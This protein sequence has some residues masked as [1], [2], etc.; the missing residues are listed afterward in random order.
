[1]VVAIRPSPSAV[2]LTKDSVKAYCRVHDLGGIKAESN[3]RVAPEQGF[4]LCCGKPLQQAPGK[5]KIK[6]C[7]AECRQRWWNAHPEAVQTESCLYFHLRP[8]RTLFYSLRQFP[9]EILL[10]RLLYRGPFQR[11]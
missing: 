5:K 2:G 1:M 7:S 6:F 11:R 8:L 3:A 9:Q 10:P 4:C